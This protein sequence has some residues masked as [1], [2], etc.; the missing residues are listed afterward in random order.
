MMTNPSLMVN[1]NP[2]LRS[3]G[4]TKKPILFDREPFWD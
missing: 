3:I 4:D 2:D 1:G